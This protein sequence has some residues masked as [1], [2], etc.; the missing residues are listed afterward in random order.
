MVN[1][2]AGSCIGCEREA[3][4]SEAYILNMTEVKKPDKKHS[5]SY[6]ESQWR[7]IP[8]GAVKKMKVRMTGGAKCETLG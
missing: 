5:C 7:A 3:G 8:D 6:S 2:R 1:I 4:R